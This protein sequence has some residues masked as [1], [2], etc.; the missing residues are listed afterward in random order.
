MKILVSIGNLEIAPTFMTEENRRLA[1]SLFDVVWCI[2]KD[3][4]DKALIKEK[5]AD[6]DAY[7]TCWGSPCL[8]VELLEGAPRLRLLAH[9]GSSV[10]SYAG[11]AVWDRGVRVISAFDYFSESTAEGAIAYMLAA[12]RRIPFDSGRLKNERIWRVEGD[13][14]NGLI[15]KTVGI[16]S[17]GGVGRHVVKKLQPFNVKL[18]VYDIVDIPKEEQEKYG[19]EQVGIEELFSTCEVIS[20]HTP[21]NPKTHHMIDDRLLSMIKKGALLVNTARGGIIDQEALTRHLAKGDFN[22]ALDVFEKEPIDMN[23]PL[24]TMDNVML[25]PHQGGPTTN[26]RAPL[27]RDLLLDA[28]AFLANGTPLRNEISRAYAANMSTK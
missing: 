22:A 9:L 11:E 5:L 8:D 2:G 20:L 23:D 16:V 26:L 12:L 24:L 19:F 21:Y 3:G 27:T 28:H 10:A 25:M 6:C 18:K 13:T 14:S 7:M 15:H 17:Y 1:E 4:A